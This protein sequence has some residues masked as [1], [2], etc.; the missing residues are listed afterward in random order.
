MDPRL[1]T[2]ALEKEREQRMIALT[3][4]AEIRRAL[5]EKKGPEGGTHSIAGTFRRVLRGVATGRANRKGE[6]PG[7]ASPRSSTGDVSGLYNVEPAAA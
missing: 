2:M 5:G 4:E 6:H 1:A 3:R 7:E